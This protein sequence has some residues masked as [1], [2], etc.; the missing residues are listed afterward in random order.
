LDVDA[1]RR[2]GRFTDEDLLTAAA[3]RDPG[4]DVGMF[5]RQLDAARRLQPAQV[6]RYGVDADGLQGV[7]ERCIQ[8]AEQLRG[9]R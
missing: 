5:A 4:F 8:W 9:T 1:I 3:D 7:K 2:D 6:A